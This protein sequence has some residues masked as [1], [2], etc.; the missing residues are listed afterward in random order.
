MCIG[1]IFWG[2]KKKMVIYVCVSVFFLFFFFW[3]SI[4]SFASFTEPLAPL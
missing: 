2:C 1:L 3:S 4:S